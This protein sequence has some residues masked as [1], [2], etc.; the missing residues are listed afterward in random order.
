MAAME[1]SR[2]YA[3]RR[4]A[5]VKNYRRVVVGAGLGEGA[6]EWLCKFARGDIPNP[7]SDRIELLVRY[8]KRLDAR[9][10]RAA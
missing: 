4:A 3:Q 6:Y 2:E 5:E 1:T 10:L 7:G 8:Y 9:K